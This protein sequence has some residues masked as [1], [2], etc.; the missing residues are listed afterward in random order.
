MITMKKKIIVRIKE[1]KPPEGEQIE[2]L[3]RQ[4]FKTIQVNMVKE[5]QKNK[6]DHHTV[7]YSK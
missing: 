6:E 1:S 5:A 7:R 4:M 2:W 3:Y